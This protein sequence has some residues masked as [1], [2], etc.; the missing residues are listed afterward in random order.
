M[1]MKPMHYAPILFN[2]SDN[3]LTVHNTFI[4]IPQNTV[5][6]DYGVE[7]AIVIGK[8]EKWSLGILKDKRG[9]VKPG[10]EVTVEIE[11]LGVLSNV[12]K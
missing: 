8:K 2:K 4:S 11:K 5:Q 12:F 3:T 1:Q 7:L 9:Y 6:L 10:D